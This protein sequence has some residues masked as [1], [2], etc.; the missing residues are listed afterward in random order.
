MENLDHR[1]ILLEL[2][3]ASLASVSGR[4]AVANY[5]EGNPL[6][7]RPHVIAVG[8][9]ACAMAQGAIDVLDSKVGDVLII[10]KVGHLE[11]VCNRS[12][13]EC[14][15]AEHPVPDE[16]SLQAGARLMAFVSERSS[17]PFLFLISGGASSLVDVLP[18]SIGLQQLGELTSWLLASGM[19][20]QDMNR[21]RRSLSCI[22]GGK[23][24]AHVDP[25]APVDVLLISDVMGDDLEAI[26]SGLCFPIR[27]VIDESILP[28]TIRDW[29]LACPQ[30]TPDRVVPHHIVASLSQ[31][32]AA[33]HEKATNIGLPVFMHEHL[34]TGDALEEGERIARLLIDEL[35]PGVHIWGGETTVRLPENPGRGGRNQHLA[36]SAARIL[37]GST[38][39][40]LLSAGT[41]GTDG[42]GSDAGALV[43]GGTIQRGLIEDQNA[44]TALLRADSG[45]FLELSGDLVSTG[46]TGTN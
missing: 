12:G 37:S 18:D 15:E 38:G 11:S 21:F 2:F 10:T 36:L 16:S 3:R 28:D 7:H 24:L 1:A 25:G 29:W 19:P 26:G 6:A 17:G 27:D 39:I 22:K 32:M 5:L 45:S 30:K 42:P 9:A 4:P 34:L 13:V 35:E 20:I 44:E 46:P 31:A 23:L 8:K 14:L 33:A 40:S 43:D 41:D